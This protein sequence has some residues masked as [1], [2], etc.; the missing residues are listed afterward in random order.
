[1]TSLPE[2][3]RSSFLHRHSLAIA[4]WV[5]VSLRLPLWNRRHFQESQELTSVDWWWSVEFRWLPQQCSNEYRGYKVQ[6][7]R[8]NLGDEKCKSCNEPQGVHRPLPIGIAS[9][10][11][12]SGHSYWM[13][14]K[15]SDSFERRQKE[16]QRTRTKWLFWR[17]IAEILGIVCKNAGKGL[18]S[19]LPF[20]NLQD[21]TVMS[22]GLVERKGE[23]FVQKLKIGQRR[24]GR[25]NGSHELIA[26]Q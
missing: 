4:Q 7:R 13:V 25:W 15:V 21:A 1:M 6:I 10:H 23:S 14:L 26:I 20:K 9:H 22:H 19:W 16:T 2:W 24:K 12:G 5:S 11:V 18:T 8:R 17:A 3:V